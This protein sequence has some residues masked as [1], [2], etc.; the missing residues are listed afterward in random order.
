MRERTRFSRK[1]IEGLPNLKLLITT[2]MR[3]ASFDLKA[4]AER[5]VTVCGTGAVGNPTT[6]IAIGLMLEL[7]AP[8]RLRKRADESWMNLGR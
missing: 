6:G 4:A 2:G 3:N 5:G 7:T 8:H 1:V